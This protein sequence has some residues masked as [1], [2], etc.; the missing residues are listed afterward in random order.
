[1][2]RRKSYLF[3][4][5]IVLFTH[6]E[7]WS[8]VYVLA[9]G[10]KTYPNLDP[11]SQLRYADSDAQD[12]AD[13]LVSLGV[14]HDDVRV[15]TNAGATREG[16]FGTIDFLS[17]IVLRND[18]LF[19]FFSGHGIVTPNG[20]TFLLPYEGRASHAAASGIP[21]SQFFSYVSTSVAASRI[22]FFLDACHSGAAFAMNSQKG[23]PETA[24]HISR[25]M[26]TSLKSSQQAIRVAILSSSS[27]EF[28]YED[29]E[30]REGIFTHY[31]I[32]GLRGAAGKSEDHGAVTLESLYRFLL[33]SVDAR[34]RE[35]DRQDQSPMR[36]PDW[37]SSLE[38]VTLKSPSAR[39]EIRSVARS[40]VIESAIS[41]HEGPAQASAK[42]LVDSMP[43]TSAGNPDTAANVPNRAA[44]DRQFLKDITGRR[45][46]A[47]ALA[48]E[49]LDKR[50]PYK[51][52]G[53]TVNG[54]D[55]SGFAAYVL[56]R[57]GVIKNPE[58]YWSGRLRATFH[59]TAPL[60][61]GDLIFYQ[62]GSCFIY[63]GNDEA[64]GM[65]A[66]RVDYFD[67]AANRDFIATGH[68]PY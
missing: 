37:Y 7:C 44:N 10:I 28:S 33:D 13:S 8:K 1:M 34:A 24:A 31:L 63:L 19:V 18:T 30:F 11:Q 43:P 3:L 26:Q 58:T 4:L 2:C 60:Q 16:I 64:I 68:V 14:D 67:L 23:G 47:V 62:D 57:V 40:N 50:V 61:P 52:G 46:E 45:R 42:D 32:E 21:P 12:F 25:E 35:K 27:N 36:S 65:S 48:L 38:L 56:S 20:D 5:F 41:A 15:L 53:K 29:D 6:S 59:S 54:F 22:I 49:L 66:T 39:D 51:W 9:I 17:R 55:G